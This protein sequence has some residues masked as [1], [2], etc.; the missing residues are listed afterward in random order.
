[1]TNAQRANKAVSRINDNFFNLHTDLVERPQCLLVPR[2]SLLLGGI[3]GFAQKVVLF[4]NALRVLAEKVPG[5][6]YIAQTTQL[7][8][9]TPHRVGAAQ[10][11][12]RIERARRDMEGLVRS[13][14]VH[15]PDTAN[16]RQEGGKVCED[17]KH[18]VISRKVTHE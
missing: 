14:E 17:R 8:S 13:V 15:A 11:L 10:H 4:Q 12:A 5:H 1:M 9:R 3:S 2:N 6:R 18:R 7:I 16:K